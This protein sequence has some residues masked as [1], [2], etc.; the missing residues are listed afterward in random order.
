MRRNRSQFTAIA[1]ALLL[2][3]Q[4]VLTPAADTAKADSQESAASKQGT[5]KPGEDTYNIESGARKIGRGIEEGAKGVGNTIAQGSQAV[6]RKIGEAA[7]EAEP[8]ATSAWQNFK[9]GAVE[10]GRSVR[11]FFSR[12]FSG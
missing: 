9:H 6:G 1:A 3:G 10:A 11:N 7:R 5:G 4:P 12:L 8:Q 2:A